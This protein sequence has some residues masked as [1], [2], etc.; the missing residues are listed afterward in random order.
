MADLRDR[1]A[2]V[3]GAGRRDGIGAAVALR[4]ARDGAHVVIGDLCGPP[5]DLPH[6]GSGRWEECVALLQEIEAL[7]VRGM[8]V[9][10]D[11][12]SAPSVEEL[13]AQVKA[14]FG[15]LD[16]LVNNAGTVVGP[17]PV[18]LMEEAAWR[19]TLE[20]NATGTFLCCKYALPLM[21]DGG[22]GGRIVNISSIA[23][24]RPKPYASAYGASKAAIVALTRSLAQ[25]VAAQGITVNSILPGDVNT[26]LKHWALGLE[27]QATGRSYEE[28][29]SAA[30]AR[31]PLG[32]FAAPEEVGQLVS[33][34]ASDEA[35]FI[36]GQAYNLTGG[37]ELT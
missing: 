28:V 18:L 13:M 12:A 16:I 14:G 11:V 36:T 10:L 33:F 23:A 21:I 15:R 24:E 27:A 29:L 2:V 20:I 9:R 5:A 22:R 19:R 25:E 31:V 35:G 4:L 7:G 8:A 6:A 30:Q 1:V 3:T 26:Q 34:L 37:R 32:R 17:S